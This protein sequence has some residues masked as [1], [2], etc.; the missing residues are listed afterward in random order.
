MK[1]TVS[2]SFL[3]ISIQPWPPPTL[4]LYSLNVVA[5]WTCQKRR[6]FPVPS[7][8]YFSSRCCWN[9]LLPTAGSCFTWLDC[10]PSFLDLQPSYYT[11]PAVTSF[12]Q[13]GGYLLCGCWMCLLKQRK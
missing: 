1:I 8:A 13:H 10:C 11:G 2:T 6:T 12:S 9:A 4:M 5:V 3:S 7:P